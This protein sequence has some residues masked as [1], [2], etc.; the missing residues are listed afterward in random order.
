MKLDSL[1]TTLAEGKEQL[2]RGEGIEGERFMENLLSK[3]E[4][5]ELLD[6]LKKIAQAG[7]SLDEGQGI[8]ADKFSSQFEKKWGIKRKTI[9]D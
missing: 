9:Q 2:D 3:H 4:I 7:Y 6:T 1:R 5:V 8:S